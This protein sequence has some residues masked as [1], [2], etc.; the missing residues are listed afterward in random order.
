MTDKSK[1]KNIEFGM[2]LWNVGIL[3][4]SDTR[5]DENDTS[6][7]FLF[8]TLNSFDSINVKEKQIIADDIS[9]IR[10]T[11]LSPR[12]VTPEATS[13]VIE[14]RASGLEALLLERCRK[15][16][17]F[18][19]LSRLFDFVTSSVEAGNQMKRPLKSGQVARITT[20]APLPPGSDAVVQVEDTEIVETTEDNKEE[21]LIRITSSFD[22]TKSGTD[23]RATGSD[24][25]QGL[26]L[27]SRGVILKSAEL[28]VL[29]TAG[30]KELE[31]YK[32]PKI[33]ILSTGNE[34]IHPSNE[35]DLPSG[36][37]LQNSKTAFDKSDVLI[38]TGGVSMGEKDL[39]KNVLVHQFGAEIVF[40]RVFM[41]PGKPMTF[42]VIPN[43]TKPKFIFALPGNPVSTAVTTEIFVLPALR[44][45][46][47]ESPF[48]PSIRVTLSED[49]ILD[50]RPEFKRTIVT[51][52]SNGEYQLSFTGNQISSRLLSCVGAN[53]LI[54]LPPKSIEVPML[55]KGSKVE[56]ILIGPL[57]PDPNS[58]SL[59]STPL[60]IHFHLLGM[61]FVL[62]STNLIGKDLERFLSIHLNHLCLS[63]AYFQSRVSSD[64]L[65]VLANKSKDLRQMGA[66]VLTFQEFVSVLSNKRTNSFKKALNEIAKSSTSKPR[67]LYSRFKA[68]M[69]KEVLGS[70]S[71]I[72]YNE[73]RHGIHLPLTI[74][75]LSSVQIG[76]FLYY[77]YQTPYN[78][79]TN[80]FI[81][82]SRSETYHQVWRIFTYSFVHSDE[83]HLVINVLIQLLVG[84][85][86]ETVHG[87]PRIMFI[88]TAG[89][90]KRSSN[91]INRR[92]M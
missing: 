83:F 18:G 32:I 46:K 64:K 24:I 41:K 59:L 53:G 75:L 40:G 47:N 89:V 13:S 48:P 73:V 60:V 2:S 58:R 88:Y 10:G 77:L 45:M 3:T 50:P 68:L 63:D 25:K 26:L 84:I 7:K 29:C 80:I 8:D 82:R 78:P 61:T 81:Y 92:R 79:E 52:L 1:S 49:I 35:I 4:I 39:L 72:K 5:T 12:D 42:A 54:R 15:D 90:F 55:A 38:T 76:F 67:S 34:L 31:V 65:V 85:P 69:G 74:P 62:F 91:I 43:P 9:K 17:P 70:E 44:S 28:G 37:F 19:S 23:V 33:S 86:L 16:H 51:V 11:G 66:N 57:Q 27:F 87:S 21:K 36:S 6:G 71:D 14:R 56:V 30:I 20:G 22:Q